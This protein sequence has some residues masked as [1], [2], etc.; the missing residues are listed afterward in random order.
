MPASA[1]AEPWRSADDQ[2]AFLVLLMRR[3]GFG[4]VQPGP[5]LWPGK[6]ALPWSFRR[7]VYF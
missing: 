6:D 4:K 2:L 1:F 7:M 3:H 5:T